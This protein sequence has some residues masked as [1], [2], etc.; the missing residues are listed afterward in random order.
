MKYLKHHPCVTL[1]LTFLVVLAC[2]GAIAGYQL[3]PLIQQGLS[4]PVD[5]VADPKTRG[6]Y[7]V[8]EQA[9]RI[10]VW[11]NGKWE[12]A[13][14]LDIR[15]R[16]VDGGE[17]GL[18]GLALHPDYP[19][20]A[21]F[22]VNYT[23]KAKGQLTSFVSEFQ[24]SSER[25]LLSY[26]QPYSNH[27]GGQVRFGPDGFLY[28]AVGDGGAA[29]DPGGN[30]QDT[31]VLLGK[32]LRVDVNGLPYVIPK[33]NPFS[34]TGGK[35]EIFAYGLR[36]PWRFSFDRKTGALFAA[37]VGQNAYEE[38]NRIE[39]GGN[40]G[41]DRMEGKHCFEPSS[42][43]DQKGLILPIW[44]YSR[45]LGISITG[46]YVYRGNKIPALDGVYVY[47]DYGSGRVWG[48]SL[49]KDQSKGE[50][51]ETILKTR[52]P[53]SAFG[54]DLDGELLIVSHVGGVYRLVTDGKTE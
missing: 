54:E 33:D 9:G 22:Y 43:C 15:K 2:S 40:Y 37:D 29:G 19:K 27:N 46:G 1:S 23:A 47:G 11:A 42:G 10:R 13:P 7:Y 45:E 28:V 25:V 48:L 24:G 39:K 51:N 21:K 16:V 4:K 26:A 50:K 38:I 32:L 3:E 35:P 20:V 44:E 5:I 31:S 41:W 17:R 49:N 12:A 34:S 53:I 30:G 52:F 14:L 6:K 8:V 36:N 18:L